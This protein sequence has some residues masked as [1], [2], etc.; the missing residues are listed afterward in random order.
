[1]TWLVDGLS[2]PK[3]ILL[4]DQDHAGCPKS[5]RRKLEMREH[6]NY[7]RHVLWSDATRL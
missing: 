4:D 7:G 1:M 6:T 3:N 2:L 5:C